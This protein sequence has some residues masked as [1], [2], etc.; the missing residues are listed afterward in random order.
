MRG[1]RLKTV[2]KKEIDLKIV[3]SFNPQVNIKTN[4]IS[5]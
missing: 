4:R 5:D 3:S 2:I 1:L